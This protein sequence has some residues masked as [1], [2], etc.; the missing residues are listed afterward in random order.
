[1]RHLNNGPIVS[2]ALHNSTCEKPFCPM[3]KQL[4]DE[5]KAPLSFASLMPFPPPQTPIWKIFIRWGKYSK[6]DLGYLKPH[7]SVKQHLLFTHTHR[8]LITSLKTHNKGADT[9]N[10]GLENEI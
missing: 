7:C 2:L 10:F 6:V 3:E 9:M 1:M 4:G 5:R 8:V